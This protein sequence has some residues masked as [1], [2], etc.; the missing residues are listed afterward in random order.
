MHAVAITPVGRPPRWDSR[1]RLGLRSRYSRHALAEPSDG[2]PCSPN[3]RRHASADY[4]MRNRTPPSLDHLVGPREQRFVPQS[5]F[6]PVRYLHKPLP[7]LQAGTKKLPGSSTHTH[8]V[9]CLYTMWR[10][11][12][13]QSTPNRTLLSQYRGHCGVSPSRKW[14]QYIEHHC[15][16]ETNI[17]YFSTISIVNIM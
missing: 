1:G 4:S 5:C 17:L 2:G 6:S 12:D 11:R 3:S 10:F 15:A 9:D 13:H 7:L 8:I 14:L 16:V